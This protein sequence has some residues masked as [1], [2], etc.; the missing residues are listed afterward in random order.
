MITSINKKFAIYSGRFQLLILK[1]C[2]QVIHCK[3]NI[4]LRTAK[5]HRYKKFQTD[6]HLEYCDT[7]IENLVL[8]EK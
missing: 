8:R 1:I 7:D 3:L 5:S 6:L 4:L 2:S